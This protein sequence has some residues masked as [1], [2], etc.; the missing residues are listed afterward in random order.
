MKRKFI[1]ILILTFTFFAYGCE[2]NEE[3]FLEEK[4]EIVKTEEEE[5]EKIE[6]VEN[7]ED[8][9]EGEKTS[10]EMKEE[11]EKEAEIDIM[12]IKPDES[13]EIMVIMYH[14]LGK[15]SDYG[16]SVESFKQD[17]QRLYDMGFRTISLKDF[18]TNNIDVE[19]GY[20]PVVLT[21]DD[22]HKSNFFVEEID[23][24]IK[25]DPDCVVGILE[26]FYNEHTDF[27]LEATF[28][29]N[30]GT[31]FGQKDYVSYKL[32]YLLEKGMDIGNHSYGHEHLKDLSG[33]SIEKTLGK[34]VKE[35][36]EIIPEYEINLLALPFGE[37]PN[38][39]R[40]KYIISGEFE[41]TQYNNIAVL[42]V[43]WKPE[44]SAINKKFNFKSIN[45]VQSGDNKFQL[46]YYLDQYE[47]NSKKRFISDGNSNII[48]VPLEKVEV[49]DEEK[50]GD[51]ELRTY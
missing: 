24:E 34:N 48:T 44:V 39:E 17:I 35:L 38:D 4:T 36:N 41:E 26:E 20:T 23:G 31:P 6:I 37:R 12:E 28:F 19:A 8:N 18:V 29:L 9:I 43:G 3:T 33:K 16:R 40:E 15:N 5:N 22:G 30:G 42:K 49:I 50:I 32:N 10:D 7:D 2:K 51:K 13:G 25:I 47:K 11:N 14:T 46:T 21:F 27:G 45:R 1:L